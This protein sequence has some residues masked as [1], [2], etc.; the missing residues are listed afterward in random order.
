MALVSR[1]SIS[2]ALNICPLSDLD[3]VQYLVDELDPDVLEPQV[4]FL[5][6]ALQPSHV[7]VE[8]D[9]EEED[10]EAGEDGDADVE[11]DEDQRRQDLQG[12]GH[13]EEDPYRELV[14][15]LRVH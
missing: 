13:A 5:E 9:E 2:F 7:G 11:V 15:P 14:D 4:P 3:P 1:Q 8:G 6:P 10:D 12:G